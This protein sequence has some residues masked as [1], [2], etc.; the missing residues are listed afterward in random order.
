LDYA[1]LSADQ[2]IEWGLTVAVHPDD[3]N[4]LTDYWQSVLAAGEAGEVEPFAGVD[5]T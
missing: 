5:N 4:G 3:L 2:A 1:G